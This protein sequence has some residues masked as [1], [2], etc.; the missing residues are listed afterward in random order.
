MS[1]ALNG[2]AIFADHA[3]APGPYGLPNAQG[4]GHDAVLWKIL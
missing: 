4:R 1:P 2:H 3:A